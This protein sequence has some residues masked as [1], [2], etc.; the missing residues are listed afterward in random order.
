MYVASCDNSSSEC[1]Q[2]ASVEC[3]GN[4]KSLT[5]LSIGDDAGV[6]HLGTLAGLCSPRK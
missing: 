5:G 4:H 6:P 2:K 1:V 3:I